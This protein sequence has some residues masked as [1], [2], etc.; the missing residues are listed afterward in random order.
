MSSTLYATDGTVRSIQPHG[1]TWSLEELQSIVGGYIEVVRTVDGKYMV[2][3]EEGKLPH[4]AL[5]LNVQATKLYVHGRR[6]YIA[7]PAVVVDT[8][9]ELDGP[10][11]EDDDGP[12]LPSF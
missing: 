4:L 7:G 8:K 3:N 5:P 10:D 6:D 2:V 11:D 1:A 12:V 9:L